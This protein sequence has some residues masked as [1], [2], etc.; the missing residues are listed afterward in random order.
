[1]EELDEI[2]AR[3]ERTLQNSRRCLDGRRYILKSSAAVVKLLKIW[4]YKAIV[5]MLCNNVT[6]L[7]EL[8]LQSVHHGAVDPYF[9]SEQL[10]LKFF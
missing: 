8:I 4:L 1:M 9:H 3:L 6:W 10:L 2:G 5:V 7:T